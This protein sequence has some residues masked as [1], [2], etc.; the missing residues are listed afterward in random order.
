MFISLKAPTVVTSPMYLISNHIKFFL[1]DVDQNYNANSIFFSLKVSQKSIFTPQ[2]Y[3]GHSMYK[4]HFW[5]IVHSPVFRVSLSF[6][7]LFLMSMRHTAKFRIVFFWEIVYLGGGRWWKKVSGARFDVIVL[8][9]NWPIHR[10][11]IEYFE[12]S[13]AFTLA[14]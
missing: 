7:E 14:K 4:I 8:L 9:H 13:E 5:W 2:Q 10:A 6:L 11:I 12:I 1:C 3:D